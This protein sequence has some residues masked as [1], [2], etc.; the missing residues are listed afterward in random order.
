MEYVYFLV[1]IIEKN[2]YCCQF[3][4]SFYNKSAGEIKG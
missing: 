2:A 3:S 4:K 1:F